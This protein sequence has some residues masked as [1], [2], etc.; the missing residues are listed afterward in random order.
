MQ[1]MRKAQ[2]PQNKTSLQP[3]RLW[4]K[5]DIEKI[6]LAKKEG[7]VQK[8]KM[9]K[10]LLLELKKL[11]SN[12]LNSEK[13]SLKQKLLEDAMELMSELEMDDSMAEKALKAELS[14]KRKE[15]DIIINKILN[16]VNADEYS[17]E[18]ERDFKKAYTESD[19]D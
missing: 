14:N 2:L 12:A 4:K 13:T 17:D 10:P 1:E 3:L 6:C 11:L 18:D 7:K 9:T 8:K 15:A 16:D 19:E 5:Q